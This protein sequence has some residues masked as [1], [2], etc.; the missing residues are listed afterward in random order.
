[1]EGYDSSHTSRGGFARS[2]N[3][4]SATRIKQHSNL[5]CALIALLL[6]PVVSKIMS[7]FSILK[8]LVKFF[9]WNFI[10][11]VVMQILLR[12]EAARAFREYSRCPYCQSQEI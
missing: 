2:H 9:L 7:G 3:K 12:N 8:L 11:E 4:V 1:M 10:L 6:F 5:D